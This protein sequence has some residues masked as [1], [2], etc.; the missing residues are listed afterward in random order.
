MIVR[1]VS[2]RERRE[3]EDVVRF[4]SFLSGKLD[5][6]G[7]SM[8]LGKEEVMELAGR[9]GSSSMVHSWASM[10]DCWEVC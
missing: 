1:F 2:L 9:E 5:E 10:A 6:E 8:A 3:E 4:E 7:A